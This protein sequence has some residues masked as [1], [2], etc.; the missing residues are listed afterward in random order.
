MNPN[1]AD[2]SYATMP[3]RLIRTGRAIQLE[4]DYYNKLEME[5]IRLGRPKPRIAADESWL[6]AI[7]EQERR[8]ADFDAEYFREF[9][10]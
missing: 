7:E 4:R 6:R 10:S 8:Y 5:R 2:N 3:Q 1:D 9:D